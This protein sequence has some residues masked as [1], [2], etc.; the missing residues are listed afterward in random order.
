MNKVIEY[1]GWKIRI[2]NSSHV[3]FPFG[4]DL[5]LEAAH[6][7]WMRSDDRAAFINE[8]AAAQYGREQIDRSK[9]NIIGCDR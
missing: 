9:L 7:F 6:G 2:F 8:D 5:W 1:K 4:V 3:E